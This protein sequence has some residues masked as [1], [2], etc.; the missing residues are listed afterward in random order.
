MYKHLSM[1][2]FLS[3]L[4]LFTHAQE[5]EDPG[6]PPVGPEEGGPPADPDAE[7]PFDGG[8]SLLLAAGAAYGAK[9]AVDYRKLVKPSNGD[10]QV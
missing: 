8:L 10:G 5:P 6:P 7:V 3:V 2:L 4:T 9:K 1:I